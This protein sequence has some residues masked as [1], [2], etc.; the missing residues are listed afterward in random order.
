LGNWV[1]RQKPQLPNYPINCFENPTSSTSHKTLSNLRFY[2]NLSDVEILFNKKKPENQAIAEACQLKTLKDFEFWC[3]KIEFAST[4]HVEKVLKSCE[5]LKIFIEKLATTKTK[6]QQNILMFA[7]SNIETFKNLLSQFDLD[8]AIQRRLLIETD[9]RGW[10]ILRYLL[11]VYDLAY[12]DYSFET[13]ENIL[14]KEGFD[15]MIIETGGNLFSDRYYTI[16]VLRLLTKYLDTKA[17]ISLTKQNYQSEL[18]SYLTEQIRYENTNKVM[19]FELL[20]S[21][22]ENCEWFGILK[23]FR[24]IQRSRKHEFL[25]RYRNDNNQTIFDV[26]HAGENQSLAKKLRRNFMGFH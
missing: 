2:S 20:I 15:A 7:A 10:N 24:L 14:G 11:L 22:T 13:S 5:N 26:V 17:I 23:A 19:K 16:F 25:L 9:I 4:E 21:I 3:F 6:N 18:C 8:L 12:I 1:F